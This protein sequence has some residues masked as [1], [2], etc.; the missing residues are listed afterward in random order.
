MKNRVLQ[1][2]Y[3]SLVLQW[4]PAIIAAILIFMVP[5]VGIAIIIAY[6]TAPILTAIRTMTR[7]PLTIATLCVMLSILFIISTFSFIALHGLMDT[8][9]IVERHLAQYTGK[10]DLSGKVFSF[11]E[12]KFIEY[13]HALLEYAI[14][15]TATFFQRIFSLFIFLVAYFFALRES[16]KNRYWFLIYFPIKMR[17]SSKRIFTKSGELIGTFFFVE[18]RL[19][20]LT[21]IVLSIGFSLL[22]FE[23]PIGNAFLVS[24]VDSLPLLG[25]GLFLLPMSAFFFYSN[26]FF[27]GVSLIL[28]YIFVL[29]TRQLAESYMWAS[30]FRVKPIHAFF[31]TVCS[32]YLF[33]LPG[34]LLTPFLLFAALKLKM[35]PYFTG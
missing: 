11:L 27:I 7:L 14:T 19:F 4:T 12:G 21:F 6:F 28:L 26:Q 1:Q 5:P 23:S 17:K 2:P 30:A 10:T 9:P 32:F 31:I 3:Q 35:N 22:G 15:F 13:G 16:G 25:I 29:T 20:L 34:I 18:A 33:G 24:L 8:I